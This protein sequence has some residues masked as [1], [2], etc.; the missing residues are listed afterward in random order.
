MT[1]YDILFALGYDDPDSVIGPYI[2]HVAN[3]GLA[4]Y[5]TIFQTGKKIGEPVYVHFLNGVF[6]AERLRLLVKL[7][8][9]EAR[10]LYC[11]YSIHDI[12]KL[13]ENR[14]RSFNALAVKET[15]QAELERVGAV[16]FFPEYQDYL[17]DITWLV[18]Y[19]S[20]HYSTAAEG[21]IPALQLYRLERERVQKVLGPLM[22]AL[23][24][25]ELST[26][27]GERA[28]KAQFLLLLNQIGEA[29]YTFVTHQVAEQR[30]LLTNVIHNRISRHL[31]RRWEMMPLLFYPEGV[32]YLVR[33][34]RMPIM[35]AD[36]LDAIGN[37]VA[38][39]A[40]SMSRG[41]YAK[42]IR[43]GNQG[44][45]VDRQCLDLGLSFED[46][47]NVVNNHVAAKVT[48]KRFKIED[49]E[50]KARSDLVAVL[51]DEKHADQRP[52][53][54]G[55]LDR[56]SLYPAS[57]AGVGTGELLRAYYIFLGDHLKK[58]VG[59][60]WQYLY[61]WLELT[62]D[63]TA[64]Y[65]LLDP[66]YQRAFVIASDLQLAIEPLYERILADG[67]KLMPEK[68]EEGLGDYAAL[69]DYTTRAVT[70]SFGGEREVDFGAALAAYVANNH[71]QCCYCGSEFPTQKWMAPVAPANV[72]VQS[73]SNRLPGG[74]H[75]EPKK[76]V[77]DVCRLQFTLEK[78]TH[79]AIKGVKTMYLH[80]Y[81]YSFYTEVFLQ[82]LRDEVRSLLAQDTSVIFPKTYEA[83]EAF[84]GNNRLDLVVAR[85]NQEGNP[86]QNGIVLPQHA[87]TIGNVLIFPLNC[88]GD[89]DSEQF[90]FGLQNALLIQRY[91][92]CKAILTDSAVP[93]LGKEDFADLFVDNAPLGFEG[94][95][96]H[97]DFDRPA[98]DR[99]WKD[100]LILH[101]LQHALYNPDRQEN[102][103]LTLA[104]ALT[105]GRLRLYF[106]ADRL[107]EHKADQGRPDSKQRAW[108]SNRLARALLPD[109]RQLIEGESSMQQ[110]ESL[111]QVAWAD[112]IIGRS[113]E[114]NSLLKPFD[115]LLEGLERKPAVFG[116]DTLRAQLSEDIFR[117]LE[118]IASE[119]YK[120]GR[121][122]REKVKAYV[123][124]FFDG[125]L[126]EAYRGNV[127]KLLADS[128]GL[129]SAYLFY[130]RE[131]IPTK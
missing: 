57:Q 35:T 42:F 29:Q 118:A 95:L 127:S 119:E 121:T 85:R 106:E 51:G 55:L 71:G 110:L 78:L 58:Q 104:R 131:Q 70:F 117:H 28:H 4:A 56:P 10:V 54:Q 122:K 111:A 108:R 107:L 53:I 14:G 99:L 63:Q 60:P 45:K 3:G 120:P 102:P 98:L 129:R 128:K 81:P 113:L 89:S 50:V 79:Q 115:M 47:F 74:W 116:F 22:R 15:V 109:L 48:G 32:A 39:G 65:N 114:R 49:M 100:M 59:D 61:T 87:E 69:A 23:D 26:S 11:A 101:R 67:A 76:Y 12:N 75:Q 66:R 82:S 130:I 88:P 31:E 112:H 77:C 27:L 94:L 103:L 13:V 84:L 52:R 124:L 92:G 126:A 80:L 123:D 21:L 105:S 96:P 33:Q 72:T 18:R 5:K 20:S 30:G 8:D 19:H 7:S 9:V 34:D 36:D 43:S 24:V 83:I 40:A 37:A 46:I 125:V 86:Y 73:F 25:L 16:D 6:T 38:R 90:L 17:E 64:S 68:E 1:N 93:I 44:I 91:F 2:K 97:D 62:P 41:E